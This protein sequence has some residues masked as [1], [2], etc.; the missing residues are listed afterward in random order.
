MSV[1]DNMADIFRRDAGNETLIWRPRTGASLVLRDAAI[2]IDE[3]LSS[4]QNHNSLAKRVAD[5]LSCDENDLAQDAELIYKEMMNAG[6]IP[7]KNS[8]DRNDVLQK[9]AE[10]NVAEQLECDVV[11][12]FF[13]RHNIPEELHLNLTNSCNEK[14]VHCYVDKRQNQFLPFQL[15]EKVLQEFRALNGATVHIS[16][17]EC[18]IHPE[19]EKVCKLC[20]DLN[21]NVIILSNLTLC[22]AARIEF[23]KTVDPQFI[24]VS[25]YSMESKVHDEIT[26][27]DGSWQKTMNAIL[28]CHNE[29]IHIRIAS[30]LLRANRFSFAELNAFAKGLHLNFVPDCS[31]VPCNNH[32]C[33]NLGYA[34]SQDELI[35]ALLDN[36]SLFDKGWENARMPD[37]D[38][39]VCDIGKSRVYVNAD[40][41]YYP[42]DS[43]NG[44]ILGSV[45]GNSLEEIW[46]GDKMNLLRELR[47]RDFMEC[48]K[49]NDRP[50]CKVCPAYNFNATGD[51]LRTIPSKCEVARCIHHVYGGKGTC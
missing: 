32:D 2:F 23:L 51:M 48:A 19:F 39:K 14:C 30:P 45:F 34:C 5:K 35:S 4:P 46:N 17:G 16:G 28:K 42:C 38:E 36:K 13:A 3:I 9:Y 24:N 18:M 44:Y 25:L 10:V 11:G 43:M 40:G 41:T 37:C 6:L 21:L 1:V 49:C 50:F 33:S 8:T 29:G 26:R 12:A 20:A 22:D 31:I 27:V 47:N 15:A 7:A